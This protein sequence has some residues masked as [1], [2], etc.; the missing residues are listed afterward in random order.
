MEVVSDNQTTGSPSVSADAGC[1]SSEQTSRISQKDD[2][3]PNA[4]DSSA[5]AVLK[6]KACQQGMTEISK[7]GNGQLIRGGNESNKKDHSNGNQGSTDIESMPRVDNTKFK[8][9][10]H[11]ANVLNALFHNESSKDMKIVTSDGTVKCHS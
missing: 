5:N 3:T 7:H 11:V 8:C 10:K 6:Q 1:V 4:E 9:S 2:W